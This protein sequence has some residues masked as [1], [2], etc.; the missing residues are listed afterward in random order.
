MISSN[1][2]LQSLFMQPKQDL[3]ALKTD[4][5]S[6]N[7]AG[8]QK[9]FAAFQQDALNLFKN[10]NSQ[11]GS[12]SSP[13][14]GSSQLSTDLNALQ[15]ALSS[16]N[17]TGAQKAFAA[18]QQDLHTAGMA[19]R[20]HGRHHPHHEEDTQN[21]AAN[22]QNGTNQTAATNGSGAASGTSGINSAA[23]MASLLSAY[24]A[25]VPSGASATGTGI[26]VIG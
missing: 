3:L 12:Q 5:S 26:G 25:F 20:H 11:P 19:H 8:A 14:T 13:Q 4:L 1:S 16:G 6:G 24:Q 22:S 15:S 7:L 18:F 10:S 17:V 2:S 23:A 21:T 9:D